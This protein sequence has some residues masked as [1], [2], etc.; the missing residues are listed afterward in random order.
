MNWKCTLQMNKISYYM[1]R[2]SMGAVLR[3]KRATAVYTL[4]DIKLR[5]LKLP[6]EGTYGVPKH[7]GDFVYLVYRL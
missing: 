7:V 5:L 3:Q 4:K 2:H 6:D 1:F